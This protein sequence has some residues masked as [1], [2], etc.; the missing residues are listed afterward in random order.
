MGK[1]LSPAMR[2]VMGLRPA[3]KLCNQILH[4]HPLVSPPSPIDF[5]E[6]PSWGWET[7]HRTPSREESSPSGTG[8]QLAEMSPASHPRLRATCG[9]RS[10]LKAGGG[11]SPRPPTPRSPSS[12]AKAG[13][14]GGGEIQTCQ[15]GDCPS[16]GS[17]C[18]SCVRG[19][20]SVPKL[21]RCPGGWR[22]TAPL[23][24]SQRLLPNSR[25][26]V[27]PGGSDQPGAEP[28][29][30]T[31]GRWEAGK[32]DTGLEE[33]ATETKRGRELSRAAEI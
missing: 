6:K 5:K 31:G 25:G 17:E 26:L 16:H 3:L 24:A 30:N 29:G 19:E 22:R 20:R 2:Q 33:P 7:L 13:E 12:T 8:R 1:L 23:A 32:R 28:S 11:G 18:R 4:R 15:P 14:P 10:R 9:E 27:P 21:R